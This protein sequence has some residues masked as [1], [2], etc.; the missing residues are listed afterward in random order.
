[1]R[2]YKNYNNHNIIDKLSIVLG[3]KIKDIPNI[4]D[5][6]KVALDIG[7]WALR[8]YVSVVTQANNCIVPQA[9]MLNA[10]SNLY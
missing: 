1:M 10:R 9:Q 4:A 8:G 2:H 3:F 7:N 6:I 5:S